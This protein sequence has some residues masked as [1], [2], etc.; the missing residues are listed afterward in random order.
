MTGILIPGR[1]WSTA[2]EQPLRDSLYYRQEWLDLLAA[3]YGYHVNVLTRTGPQGEITGFLPLCPLQS[4]L[5]G[6][7]LVALP[8]SDHCP[9]LA[10]DDATANQLVDQ[11]ICLAQ[12]Q[13]AKYLEL[14]AGTH[15]VLA[16]R[17][18]LAEANL[19]VRWLLALDR[20]PAAVW[21]GLRKPVQRQ[22]E[23]S[24]KSGL[25]VRTAERR[26]DMRH[27]Y[28]LHLRT[29]TK[30]HGMPTQ[31]EP[32]FLALWDA[33]AATGDLHL[34]LAESDGVM[35]A[36][37]LLLA[38][39][40]TVRY[41]YGASDD[42]YLHLAPNNLLMWT[43]IAWACTQGYRSLDLG[44]TARDNQGLMEFKRR[45]GATSEP[46]PYY[47]YPQ[48]AGLAATSES[49]WT[50]RALTGCWKRLPLPAAKALGA[51]LY[52]HLG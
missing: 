43:A 48:A 50:Y 10:Q 24:R 28:R 3:L 8:F 15:H 17:A 20:D 16:G 29:R 4:A 11:A 33:F 44:R 51:H 32:F 39:G 52:K 35:V 14:R 34:L 6:R 46:L 9:L 2:L 21:A 41:A 38:S 36:G 7:R 49:S 19:Y 42:R 18:D 40:S 22:I 23:K 25:Q 31:P 1:A 5:R 13:G 47:Y 37:M 45:W 30:K 26:E 27:Y 12:Q